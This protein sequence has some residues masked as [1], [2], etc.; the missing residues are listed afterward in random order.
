MVLRLNIKF[1]EV[2]QLFLLLEYA[3]LVAKVRTKCACASYAMCMRIVCHARSLRMLMG[4]CIV[5]HTHSLR[6]LM[7]MRLVRF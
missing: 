3:I 4:M 1:D 2:S 6:M 7:G 5:C